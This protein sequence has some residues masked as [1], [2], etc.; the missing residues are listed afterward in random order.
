YL[1]YGVY[2]CLNIVTES[3]GYPAAVLIRA[4]EP[5]GGWTARANGPGLLC[6]AMQIDRR[7][8]GADL[9]APPLTIEDHG[10]AVPP[11]AA[12]ERIGIDYAGPWASMPWRYTDPASPCLSR[13]PKK[14][15]IRLE[16]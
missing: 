13:R 4:V 3:E 6:R 16:L 7:L 15:A 12:D 1:I 8:N 11:L 10:W 5:L 2:H 9:T 14:T